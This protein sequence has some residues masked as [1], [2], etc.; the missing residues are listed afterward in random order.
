MVDHAVDFGISGVF[1]ISTLPQVATPVF[2]PSSGHYFTAQS[3]QISWLRQ[4][5]TFITPLTEANQLKI[6]RFTK[7]L[8]RYLLI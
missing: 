5:Q 8:F 1:T 7:V 6:R 2:D 3:V 4:E